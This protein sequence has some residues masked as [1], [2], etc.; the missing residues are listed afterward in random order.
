M[1]TATLGSCSSCSA[2]LTVQGESVKAEPADAQ[3]VYVDGVVLAHDASCPERIPTSLR[4]SW[5][6]ADE[7]LDP[8]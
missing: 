5:K 3:I 8:S 2:K 1:F 4:G 6:T 7:F